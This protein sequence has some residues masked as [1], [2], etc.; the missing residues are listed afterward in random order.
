MIFTAETQ[1]VQRKQIIHRKGAK[2][3]K[4]DIM[5]KKNSVP[6]AVRV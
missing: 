1:R 2:Y 4:K 3:A 6:A 5:C